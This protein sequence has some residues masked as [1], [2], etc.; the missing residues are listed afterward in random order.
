MSKFA[1]WMLLGLTL[2]GCASGPSF[3]SDVDPSANFAS[4]RTFGWVDE[5]GTQRAGYSELITGHFRDAVRVEMQ[6]LG[7]QFTDSNPDLLVNFAANVREREDLKTRQSPTV[8]MSMGYGGYYGYR[9]GIYATYPMY[10]TSVETV[11]Y[12]EGT[13]NIDVVDA[14]QSRLLWE[15][16]A[17]GRLTDKAMANPRMAI[18]NVVAGIFELYPTA[19]Q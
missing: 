4:Y 11:R 2:T 6:K 10:D 18:I 12:K 14:T 1:L 13:V 7:Y 16:V 5:F 15:G 8:G 17:E 3:R 9:R 19:P